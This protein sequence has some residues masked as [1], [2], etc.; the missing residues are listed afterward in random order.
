MHGMAND[1]MKKKTQIVYNCN[2]PH[3]ETELFEFPLRGRSSPRLLAKNCY[4]F[5]FY[6]QNH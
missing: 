6:F 5:S 2:E 3:W 1:E 4:F